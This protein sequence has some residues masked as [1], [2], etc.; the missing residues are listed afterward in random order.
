[1]DELLISYQLNFFYRLDL[2]EKLK[3]KLK[4]S[5]NE[6]VFYEI[7]NDE[8]KK[9]LDKTLSKDIYN[10]R[11]ILKKFNII[12]ITDRTYPALLKEIYGPPAVLFCLGDC[13]VLLKNLVSIVGTRKPTNYGIKTALK[14]SEELS[15]LGI[16]VVS[17]FA[18]GID[19]IS[20]KTAFKNS[21]TIAVLGSGL[22]KVYPSGN[23][24]LFEKIVKTKNSCIISEFP[25]DYPAYKRNFPLRNRIIAGLSPFTLVIEAAK[26]SGSLI[27]AYIALDSGRDVGAVPGRI[28]SEASEGTNRLIRDGAHVITSTEDILEILP[29]NIKKRGECDEKKLSEDELYV[30][31]NIPISET[32]SFDELYEKTGVSFSKLLSILTELKLSGFVIEYPGK[33]YERKV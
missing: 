15:K 33:M 27:T 25:P 8:E 11:D 29:Y 18:N 26:K 3:L 21:G 7:L 22:L 32:V 9:K 2:L 20:Q 17:G 16:I 6:K 1:M 4:E 12:K 31:R 10:I 23:K 28:D 24:N 30:L 13:S 5:Q 19:T 14:F